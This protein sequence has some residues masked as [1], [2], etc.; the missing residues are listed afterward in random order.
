MKNLKFIFNTGEIDK[1]LFIL[2]IV[3]GISF[4]VHGYPK[5]IGGPEKWIMIGK[6]MGTVGITFW[7]VFWGFCAAISEFF[8]GI[9]LVIGL[10]TKIASSGL[11]F[12]MFIATV[13][14]LSKGDGFNRFSHPIELMAVCIL[15]I[16]IGAG[17]YSLDYLVYKKIEKD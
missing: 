16:L 10:L 6:A 15:F 9:A 11:G 8:G 13:M 7:P 4:I 3:I 14:H 12:T 1:A 5:I 17:K 2:R